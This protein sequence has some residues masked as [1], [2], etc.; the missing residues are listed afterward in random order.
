MNQEELIRIYRAKDERRR[1]L[2]GPPFDEK[3]RI[4]E[5]LQ[6]LGLTML[7]ER[8][9]DTLELKIAPIQQE[10]PDETR[11]MLLQRIAMR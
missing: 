6:E 11:L 1:E 4:I 8:G 3:V 7:L 2:A 5:Q 10:V 9:E